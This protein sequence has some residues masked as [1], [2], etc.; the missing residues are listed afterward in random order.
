MK[1]RERGRE[2]E[3]EKVRER[4]KERE[5]NKVEID[6]YLLVKWNKQI[7]LSRFNQGIHKIMTRKALPSIK[8]YIVYY[9]TKLIEILRIYKYQNV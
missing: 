6:T 3:R 1:G 5:R 7:K 4:E 8:K 9:Y 2:R